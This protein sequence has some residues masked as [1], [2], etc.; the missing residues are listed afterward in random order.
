M[1]PFIN[2]TFFHFNSYKEYFKTVKPNLNV[3]VIKYTVL[4]VIEVR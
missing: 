3:F 1:N 4:L 2:F